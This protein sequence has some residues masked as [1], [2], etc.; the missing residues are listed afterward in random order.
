MSS[1]LTVEVR[2]AAGT[3][4]LSFD[5]AF[6]RRV[7]IGRASECDLVVHDSGVSRKH[8]M[9]L[10]TPAG[11]RVEDLG[12]SNGTYLNGRQVSS[13]PFGRGDVVSV[14]QTEIALVNASAAPVQLVVDLAAGTAALGGEA[15]PLSAAELIWF[16]Y[17]ASHRARGDGWVLAGRDGHPE[18]ARWT[19]SLLSREWASGVKT[20]PLLDLAAGEDVDDEDLKNL[21]GKTAQKLR[22]FCSGPR[23]W[24]APLL[25]PEVQGKNR[26][27]LPLASEECVVR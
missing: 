11:W 4:T 8:T 20:R 23:G 21:R 13:A 5:S 17:L 9:L 12:S 10:S 6:D 22:G 14:G 7:I 16:S 18:L 15:L 25:V 1:V 3:K 24:M 27:R 2:T 19:K 26:Q